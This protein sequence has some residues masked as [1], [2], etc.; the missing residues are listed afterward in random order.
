MAYDIRKR[1]VYAY[2]LRGEWQV[3]EQPQNPN[4]YSF[5]IRYQGL[6]WSG[7]RIFEECLAQELSKEG[8]YTIEEV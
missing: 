1:K 6:D 5:I 8:P 2:W 4:V 7:I 3:T